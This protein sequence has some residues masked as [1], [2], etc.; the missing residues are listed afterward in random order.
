[1][2]ESLQDR[3][4]RLGVVKGARHLKPVAPRPPTPAPP[5]DEPDEPVPLER[6]L[7][8]GQVE[9]TAVGACYV[10]D[11]VYPLAYR[12]GREPLVALLAHAPAAAVPYGQ[13]A[14][15]AALDFRDL[16]FLDTETTG[17]AGAGTLAFMVGAAFFESTPAGEAFVVRQYFLRDHGDEAAMLHLLAGLLTQKAGVVTFNGRAFDLPLL[18]NRYLLNRMVGPIFDLPHVDL[19]HPARRL[20]RA[21]LG[22]CALGALEQNLLEVR[23]TQEDVP[24]WLIPSL[25]QDYLRS[26]DAR[27]LARVFYH[28]R[29]DMLS[30]VTLAT[31]VWRFFEGGEAETHPADWY[32]LGKWQADLD[33]PEAAEASLRRA[34]AGE[35]LPLALYHETLQRLGLLLKRSDRRAEAL[36][37]WQQWAATSYDSVEPHVELAKYYEWHAQDVETAVLW[38][39]RALSLVESWSPH[40]ARLARDELSHRLARLLGKRG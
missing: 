7:A 15:L 12:H 8:G 35:D 31:R 9:A 38:T 6:L 19:L 13:D 20:W 23:R 36:P 34:L 2:S 25:Y 26:G 16:V 29:I 1:M 39:E 24:G 21:R 5:P 10:L 17:L 40:R 30:M 14:R 28:N 37:L 27:E 22:S 11:K 3:L 32:S 4:R 33:A 18:D